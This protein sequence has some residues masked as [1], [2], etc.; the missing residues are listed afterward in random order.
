M[1]VMSGEGR[2]EGLTI[3]TAAGVL[4]ENDGE[5]A[6]GVFVLDSALLS[7]KHTIEALKW[8]E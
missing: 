2:E 6:K 1:Y 3:G 7:A 8:S 4:R 5:S